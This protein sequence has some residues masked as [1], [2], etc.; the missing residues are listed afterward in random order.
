MIVVTGAAGF[1]GSNLVKGLNQ[2]GRS[3]ILAVDDLSDGTKFINLVDAQIAD[4]IDKEQFKLMC[5]QNALD[6]IEVIFHQGACSETT[7]WDGIKMMSDNYDYSKIVLAYCQEHSIP[8]IYASSAA[9][10]GVSEAFS[11]H[12]ANEKPLN[13]Y[14]YSKLLF[15]NYVR[16]LKSA[17]SPIVGLRYFNVYGSGEA[18]KGSMASTTY[19][20]YHQV[21]QKG[22]LKLFAGCD[23]YQDG[24]QT[25]DFIFVQ[26]IVDINIW[27]W[28]Q[29]ISGIFNAGTGQA[30]T[31]NDMAQCVLDHFGDGRLEYIPFPE[32]LKGRYQSFTQA[33]MQAL[34]KA[35]YNKGFTSLEQ[36][37]AKYC[38][39]LSENQ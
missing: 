18:H 15:D 23:G 7:C 28:Q 25:R 1:I 19:H 2:L 38:N 4:Y 3:D 39:S 32:H 13:V 10:Y 14:G 8:L 34:Q 9:V 37:V 20:F 22:C 31:F 5:Q 36:G 24:E 6:N 30:R 12:P 17:S 33:D 35:G 27:C 11:E 29:R 16:R 26:D 21:K